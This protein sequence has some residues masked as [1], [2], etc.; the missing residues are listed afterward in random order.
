MERTDVEV[1]GFNVYIHTSS[2]RKRLAR[3]A[4][5]LLHRA[6]MFNSPS[7]RKDGRDTREKQIGI[8]TM[9]MM[10]LRCSFGYLCVS[11]EESRTRHAFVT[12][13]IVGVACFSGLHLHLRVRLAS[14]TVPCS[15]GM[16]SSHYGCGGEENPIKS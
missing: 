16:H 7:P 2:C 11:L 1:F 4:M 6:S 13:R 10:I 14:P 8:V 9:K 12:W 15:H 3:I 5:A